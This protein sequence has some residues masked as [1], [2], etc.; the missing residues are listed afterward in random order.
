VANVVRGFVINR[1]T[2]TGITIN[3]NNNVVA[4]NWIGTDAAGTAAAANVGGGVR[5]NGNSNTIGGTTAADRNVISGNLGGGLNLVGSNAY[6]NAVL[7]NYIGTN[8]RAAP[9]S[10][11]PARRAST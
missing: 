8:A 11:T 5:V 9:P 10:A 7:G 6:Y 1:F 3:G 2:Q 4:G